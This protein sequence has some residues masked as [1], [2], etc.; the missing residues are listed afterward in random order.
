MEPFRFRTCCEPL[1]YDFAK[2]QDSTN[3]HPSLAFPLDADRLVSCQY[4]LDQDKRAKIYLWN[5]QIA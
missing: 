1:A 3:L 2:D 4:G 5:E